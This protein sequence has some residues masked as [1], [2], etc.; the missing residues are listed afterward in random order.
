MGSWLLDVGWIPNSIALKERLNTVD[1][2]YEKN[3]IHLF[4][5]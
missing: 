5:T 4:C 2:T 3:I 1:T